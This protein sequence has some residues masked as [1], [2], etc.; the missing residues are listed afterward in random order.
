M[1][2]VQAAEVG[3]TPA[4]H[5]IY[6]RVSMKCYPSE[7]PE[8]LLNAI[9]ELSTQLVRLLR[10]GAVELGSRWLSENGGVPDDFVTDVHDVCARTSSKFP[11]YFLMTSAQLTKKKILEFLEQAFSANPHVDSE[12]FEFFLNL[13][14]AAGEG[15]TGPA[16]TLYAEVSVEEAQRLLEQYV[17]PGEHVSEVSVLAYNV[18]VFLKLLECSSREELFESKTVRSLGTGAAGTGFVGTALVHWGECFYGVTPSRPNPRARP[19]HAR[20]CAGHCTVLAHASGRALLPCSPHA[21][22]AILL[23]LITAP[24]VVGVTGRMVAHMTTKAI[25]GPKAGIQFDH[26]TVLLGIWNM[27]KAA[28]RKLVLYAGLV[29]MHIDATGWDRIDRVI[30][31]QRSVQKA[32]KHWLAV[33]KEK[34]A[35][36]EAV[37]RLTMPGQTELSRLCAVT[38]I[39]VLAHDDSIEERIADSMAQLEALIAGNSFAEQARFLADQLK[40]GNAV[41]L[42]CFADDDVRLG[43]PILCGDTAAAQIV[44][45][46]ELPLAFPEALAFLRSLK[47]CEAV[48]S[49]LADDV[50]ALTASLSAVV[51]APASGAAAAA[52]SGGAGAHMGSAPRSSGSGTSAT[53][54]QAR[55]A[56]SRSAACAA[57]GAAAATASGGSSSSAAAAAS[58]AAP[59]PRA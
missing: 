31:P 32:R 44:A 25:K 1:A 2:T 14:I 50:T 9:K 10:D 49:F 23:R 40:G 8:Y 33:K 18:A 21:L 35:V 36:V 58:S 55:S 59:R 57:A 26:T 48:K 38:D 6:S 53:A 46:S 16:A 47:K 34:V 7:D 29:P 12:Q 17:Q 20:T 37:L 27:L 5:R 39:M 11:L 43:A 30:V 28:G 13:I 52:A 4:L 24:P 3:I 45:V 56:V 41:K 51:L 42:N 54:A 15:G 19:A 22:R